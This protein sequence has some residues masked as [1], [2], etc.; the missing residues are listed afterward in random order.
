PLPS[1]G[2]DDDDD[3]DATQVAAVP[4]ELLDALL[5]GSVNR[6]SSNNRVTE[7]PPAMPR[8]PGSDPELTPIESQPVLEIA[9]DQDPE[10]DDDEL[11]DLLLARLEEQPSAPTNVRPLP[12]KSAGLPPAPPLIATRLSQPNPAPARPAQLRASEPELETDAVL[13]D[14]DELLPPVTAPPGEADKSTPLGRLTRADHGAKA[15]QTMVS[16]VKTRHD[17]GPLSMLDDS[18]KRARIALLEALARTKSARDQAL[19]LVSAAELSEEL[20]DVEGAKERYLRAHEAAPKLLSPIW[21]LA[22]FAFEARDVDQHLDWLAKASGAAESPKTRA[23]ALAASARVHWLVQRD[24][25]TALRAATEAAQL[26]PDD[27]AHRL[28]ETRISLATRALHADQGLVQLSAALGEDR[29]AP[30]LTLFAGRA[31][32]QRG[33]AAAARKA[34]DSAA[35]HP[36]QRAEAQLL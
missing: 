19:L 29:V 9:E 35:L 23:A 26:C 15:A 7:R 32:E 27:L 30:A 5:A 8:D 33:E 24:L 31:R 16:A 2:L 17:S 11:E 34:Y 13:N 4:R 6:E 18:G 3:S 25:P 10:L 36:P 12:P 22:R 21:A 20:S 14:L 28:L 1:L